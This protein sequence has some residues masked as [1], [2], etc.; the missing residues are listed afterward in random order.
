[1]MICVINNFNKGAMKMNK[2]NSSS[3]GL[4]FAS[5]LTIVF[6]VLKLCGQISWSWVWVLS[7]LW[8]DLIIGVLICVGLVIYY[9]ND[10]KKHKRGKD[11]WKF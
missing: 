5:L 3:S 2:N 10:N 11:E 8:I 4:G 7:P 6:I 9:A 1:M